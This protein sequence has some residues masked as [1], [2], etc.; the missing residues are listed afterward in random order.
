MYIKIILCL[1]VFLCGI[2]AGQL[3]AK[4]YDN[5]LSHLQ[6]C[7]TALKILESEMKYRLDPLPV[8][9]GRVSKLKHDISG[10]LFEKVLTLLNSSEN[11]DFTACWSE[12][13]DKVFAD[14]TLNEQDKQILRDLGIELGKTDME[15][16]FS[17]FSRAF[18]LLDCQVAE[19]LEIK[20]IKGRMYK[21]LGAAAGSAIVILL[22]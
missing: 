3:K 6:D 8:L 7:I 19:A 1:I 18:S 11:P 20:K 10:A 12:A 5:R 9:L 17:L 14:S 15:S 22:F 2:F 4:T 16:Q 21:S 13:I